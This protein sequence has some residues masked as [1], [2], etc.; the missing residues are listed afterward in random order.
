MLFVVGKYLLGELHPQCARIASAF[1]GGVGR[2]NQ[3]MCGGL[4]GGLLIIGSLY[5]RTDL[6][7]DDKQVEAIG[8]EFRERFLREFGATR[9]ADVKKWLMDHGKPEKC[10]LVVE[11]GAIIL[12]ELL[13]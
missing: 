4:S 7:A 5:G 12:L 3:E 2:T 1:S 8:K 11:R 9:C 10:D 13:A 6:N